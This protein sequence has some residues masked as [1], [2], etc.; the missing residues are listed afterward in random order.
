MNLSEFTPPDERATSSISWRLV[1]ISVLVLIIP[2]TLNFW[3]KF[4][5]ALVALYLLATK[6]DSQQSVVLGLPWRKSEIFL[7]FGAFFSASLVCL[8]I[9]D[10]AVERNE[11]SVWSEG[12]WHLGWRLMPLTQ[13]LAEEIVFRAF[14][15]HH[16]LERTHK[17]GV[18]CATVALF[19]TLWHLVFFPFTEGVWLDFS[20][21]L[22]IFCFGLA[23]NQ[24]FLWTR[25]IWIPWGIH[26]G[27]NFVKFSSDYMEEGAI[28]KEA[29]VFNYIEGSPWAVAA[30]L[31]LLLS[32]VILPK[33]LSKTVK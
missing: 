14:V 12:H 21:L 19:F 31:M 9:T 8:L 23:T 13:S 16:F 7:G 20:T 24:I 22:T 33:K 27:W 11:L 32:S 28:L 5:P 6:A 29:E 3:W 1:L 25:T 2:Y 26:A 10:I 4:I 18:V 15:L 17:S 30:S